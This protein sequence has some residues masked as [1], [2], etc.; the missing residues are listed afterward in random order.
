MFIVLIF[1]ISKMD[2][3]EEKINMPPIIDI[4]HI[5]SGVIKGAIMPAKR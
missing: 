1:L 2:S 4:S 5:S 3:P